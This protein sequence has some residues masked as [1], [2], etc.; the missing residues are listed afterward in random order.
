MSGLRLITID[1]APYNRAI[2]MYTEYRTYTHDRQIGPYKSQ[3][4]SKKL[5][6]RVYLRRYVNKFMVPTQDDY[7]VGETTS[8]WLVEYYVRL[9]IP[10]VSKQRRRQHG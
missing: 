8:S 4:Q 7:A 5:H 1:S 9:Y 2:Y 6:R 3:M 10:T